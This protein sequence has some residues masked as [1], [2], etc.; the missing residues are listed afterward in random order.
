M[1]KNNA[2]QQAYFE[3]DLRKIFPALI[4]KMRL[5]VLFTMIGGCL[6]GAFSHFV[7]TPQY[8]SISIIYAF[9]MDLADDFQVIVKTR[10]VLKEV[11]D[12][13]EL[14]MNYK[15]LEKKINVEQ[16]LGSRIIK[17]SVLD[18]DPNHA[19]QIV[20]QVALTASEFLSDMIE[21]KACKI[22]EKGV[23]TSVP[24]APS[25]RRNTLL[26]GIIGGGLICG[27]IIQKE[28]LNDT[29]RTEEDVEKYVGLKVLTSVPDQGKKKRKRF[30][31]RK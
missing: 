23:V 28:I 6:A 24:A 18:P 5:I 16:E 22:I 15:T 21:S 27:L 3:I 1:E 13:L 11:I 25:K 29:I 30:R 4:Q 2:V 12:C 8:E 19:K 20:D 17:I 9:S 10:P 26:G 7:L 31:K 14:D